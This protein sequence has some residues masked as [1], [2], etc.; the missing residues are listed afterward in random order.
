MFGLRGEPLRFP[1]A[2]R[3][4]NAPDHF[5]QGQM[6]ASIESGETMT[7]D[8]WE[9]GYVLQENP[10]GTMTAQ[11]KYTSGIPPLT[12]RRVPVMQSKWEAPSDEDSLLDG[13]K[14][15]PQDW[16]LQS[17]Q[18]LCPNIDAGTGASTAEKCDSGP[19]DEFTIRGTEGGSLDDERWWWKSPNELGLSNYDGG[20]KNSG[21]CKII[22]RDGYQ[23]KLKITFETAGDYDFMDDFE[24]DFSEDALG[25]LRKTAD[26][27]TV[28]MKGGDKLS[29]DIDSDWK[30]IARFYLKVQGVELQYNTGDSI[31]DEVYI[32]L[33]D[34]YIEEDA[35][36]GWVGSNTGGGGGGN[37][38]DEE[39]IDWA[40]WGVPAALGG[41]LLLVLLTNR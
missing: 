13:W 41:G 36:D 2:F 24:N 4:V 21:A 10:D 35:P 37:D 39:G 28:L 34:V 5:V 8:A 17:I 15:D 18:A 29:V 14:K 16:T 33:K 32:R 23:V 19:F 9:N 6:W 25:V 20:S 26:S 12:L 38:D 27:V 7:L 30:G 22:V 11:P 3:M 40:K 1:D 31:D